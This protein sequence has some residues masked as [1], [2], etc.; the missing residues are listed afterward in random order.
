MPVQICPRCQH[1]N[2]ESAAFCYFDGML[3]RAQGDGA[4]SAGQLAR[5]FIFP[6]GRRC[7][8]FDEFAQGCQEEWTAARDLLGQGVL[9]QYFGIV[10]RADLARVA[11]EAMTQGDGDI[12]LSAVLG[13][14]PVSRTLQPKL[15]I[16][17][18]R[19]VL[20]KMLVG[21]TRQMQLTL[22]NQGEGQLQGT[23]K[24]SEG[25]NWITIPGHGASCPISTPRE[26]KVVLQV[27]TQ[28]L[29][30]LQNYAG[31]LTVVTN[32][33]IVEVPIGLD[34]VAQPFMK[35]PYQ[36]VKTPREM[37]ERMR[38]QAKAAVP[39][40]ESGDI[41][42]WF[43]SNN[44]NFPVRG[45]TIKGVAGVQ[46]F[47]EAMGLSKPPPLQ[48]SQAEF[49][50]RSPGKDPIRFQVTLSTPARKW[51]YAVTES[52][53]SWLR[54]LTPEVS[55]PQRANISFEVVGGVLRGSPLVEAKLNVVA[56]AG[57]KL[58][59]RVVVESDHA[60]RAGSPAPAPR[61]EERVQVQPTFQFEQKESVPVIQREIRQRASGGWFAGILAVLVL[62]VGVRVALIPL[63]DF[64]LRGQ[65]LQATVEKLKLPVA[66]DSPLS[67]TGGWLQL[68]WQRIW[69]Q[70]E[71]SLPKE[72]FGADKE[73][74]LGEF[75]HYFAKYFLRGMVFWLWWLGPIAGV[76]VVRRR[77]G[78]VLDWPWGLIA[79]SVAGIIGSVTLGSVLLAGELVPHLLWSLVFTGKG[80]FGL[81]IVWILLAVLS[82]L[83]LGLFVGLLLSVLGPIGRPLVDMSREV[84]AGC[85]RMLGLR[86]TAELFATTR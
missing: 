68:P 70:A 29:V 77:G 52:D 13:A 26:Q 73:V 51:V 40:L 80:D 50:F 44:W 72:A 1:V 41:A 43:A 71:G 67:Q 18:R 60:V 34:L 57:Q 32:G 78:G 59:I 58:P 79:G 36:G 15:D 37:A 56:N 38:T 19:L 49:R 25:A 84:L 30:A 23:L 8:T 64:W 47:F 45:Q 53:Q 33:G 63:I 5:E 22:T 46:Q 31:K 28:T 86:G 11:Q 39:L 83:A 24:I 2:P 6:S 4:A 14:L 61:T 74:N 12:A 69:M 10:G 82:W 42:R 9:Q 17:P 55:G 48:L 65:A 16:H 66:S 7:R 20:G 54:V 76:L 81:L 35:S 21:E 85:C 27:N 3:L 75:R 62:C